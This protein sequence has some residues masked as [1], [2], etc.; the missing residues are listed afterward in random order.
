MGMHGMSFQ[1]LSS[2]G[3][4]SGREGGSQTYR[5]SMAAALL[6]PL[7]GAGRPALAS[8]IWL[9][10]AVVLA[11]VGCAVIWCTVRQRGRGRHATNLPE[12][13]AGPASLDQ[14]KQ[15]PLV[16][17]GFIIL[18]VLLSL[19]LPETAV[20]QLCGLRFDAPDLGRL[21]QITAARSLLHDANGRLI[22]NAVLLGLLGLYMEHRLGALRTLAVIVMG[23]FITGLMKRIW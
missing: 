10:L 8:L 14:R 20:A 17:L 22:V 3:R 18:S 21:I 19:A 6:L 12:K 4:A 11:M 5:L 16:T 13:D 23:S 1:K 2:K 9:A 7:F 15:I